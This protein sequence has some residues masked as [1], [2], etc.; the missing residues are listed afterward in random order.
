MNSD[1][2]EREILAAHAEQLNAGLRGTAA[3]PPM[4][5][6]QQSSLVPLLQL[7]E[8]LADVLI[9]VQPSPIFVQRLGQ[10]LALAAL[11]G[12]L[13]LFERY[14]KAILLGLATIGSTLSLV[15]LFKFYRLRQREA[16]Q[17]GV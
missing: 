7:A 2:M 3:Y 11:K 5:V 1:L 9:L 6:E 4:S 16:P 15:G 17:S 8:L 13:P 14:R 12:Q 10:E